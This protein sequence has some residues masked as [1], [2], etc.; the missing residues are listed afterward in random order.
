MYSQIA[1][2]KRRTVIIMATFISF[3]GII[4]WLYILV[5]A[6]SFKLC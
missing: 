4:A 6:Y 5:P 3:V 2:N 1:A